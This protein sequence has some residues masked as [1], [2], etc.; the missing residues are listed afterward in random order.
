MERTKSQ[1]LP[2]DLHGQAGVHS[3]INAHK[4]DKVAH[5]S[6]FHLDKSDTTNDTVRIQKFILNNDYKKHEI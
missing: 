6:R 4:I 3:L 2:S 1:K 5:K